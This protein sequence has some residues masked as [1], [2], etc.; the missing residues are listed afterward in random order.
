MRKTI[1][2][3]LLIIVAYMIYEIWQ[4]I[5]LKDFVALIATIFFLLLGWFLISIEKAKK[6]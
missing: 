3:A 4:V 1:K 5:F 6:K 2:I